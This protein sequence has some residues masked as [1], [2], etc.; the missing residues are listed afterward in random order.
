MFRNVRITQETEKAY[1]LTFVS[2][3]GKEAIWIPKSA[4]ISLKEKET[5]TVPT[6]I[7]E[8]EIKDWFYNQ[9]KEKKKAAKEGPLTKRAKE[10]ES[11]QRNNQ[12]IYEKHITNKL[13]TYLK[14]I[15][16]Q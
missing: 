12:G 13:G 10:Q 2:S 15:R 1:L 4:I 11:S 5:S 6:G 3:K 8:V 7:H 14:K 9:Y 16:K